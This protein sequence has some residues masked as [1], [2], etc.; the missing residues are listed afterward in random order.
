MSQKCD[1]C[2]IKE[3][4]LEQITSYLRE[5]LNQEDIY[6]DGILS[7]KVSQK[8]DDKIEVLLQHLKILVMYLRFEASASNKEMF[9]IRNLIEE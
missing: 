3:E 2:R 9:K 6:S 4:K 8:H 1:N 5:I 7:R